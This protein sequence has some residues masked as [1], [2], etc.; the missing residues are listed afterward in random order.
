MCRYAILAPTAI[1]AGFVDAK[2]A[3]EKVM[4]A[5]EIPEDNYR[6]GLTKASTTKAL[7]S[8]VLFVRE[9]PY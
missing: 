6:I 8:F 7:P 3:T 1:P 5:I 9:W 4:K 2:Q